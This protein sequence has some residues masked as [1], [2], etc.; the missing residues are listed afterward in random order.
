M[1][2]R[3]GPPQPSDFAEVKYTIDDSYKNFIV[4]NPPVIPDD[5]PFD[6]W[7]Q[8]NHALRQD[9]SKVSYAGKVAGVVIDTFS[10]FCGDVERFVA[11]AG[12]GNAGNGEIYGMDP[13]DPWSQESIRTSQMNDYGKSQEMAIS[14]LRMLNRSRQFPHVVVLGHSKARTK[15]KMVPVGKGYKEVTEVVGYDMDVPGR[16]W[17]GNMTKFFEQYVWMTNDGVQNT[18]IN[19]H[20]RSDGQFKTKFRS[21]VAHEATLKVPFSYEGQAD[22]I[23]RLAELTNVDLVDPGVGLRTCCYG[24]GGVGKTMLW[25]SWPPEVFEKLGPIVY[26]PFDPSAGRLA[27]T[28]PELTEKRAVA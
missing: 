28:W 17:L 7:G 2:R 11:T 3:P 25:T 12:R 15:T 19:L 1:N 5:M 6:P 23:R 22:V 13:T 24:D 26:F 4:V 20:L 10:E 27:S 18:D 14:M 16:K 8:L 9:W 21:T